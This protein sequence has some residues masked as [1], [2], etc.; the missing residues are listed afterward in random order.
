LNGV[1]VLGEATPAA[2]KGS[3]TILHLQMLSG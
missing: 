2:S 1:A 3:D